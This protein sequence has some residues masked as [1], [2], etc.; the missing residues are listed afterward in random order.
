ME[1]VF[2]LFRATRRALARSVPLAVRSRHRLDKKPGIVGLDA[3][4][5]QQLG[6]DPIG[7]CDRPAELPPSGRAITAA[8]AAAPEPGID[9]IRIEIG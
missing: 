4:A 9:G 6:G 5:R 2:L 7:R 3:R 8:A 1:L